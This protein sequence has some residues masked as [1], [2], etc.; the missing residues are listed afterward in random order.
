VQEGTRAAPLI[1]KALDSNPPWGGTPTAAALARADAYFTTGA[2][3]SLKGEKYV[4]L[5]T[6]GGPNCNDALRC[7]IDQCT[8]NI[9]GK[10]CGP[11][12]TNCCDPNVDE[13]GP[14]NCLD[15]DASVAAV[16]ALAKHGIKTFVVGIPGTEAYESTLDALAAKSGVENPDAPPAYFA[17]SAKSG[18][19]GLSSTLERITAGLITSCRL[20]LESVPPVLNDV[21]VVI[22]GVEIKHDDPDGWIYDRA[23]TPPA[24]VLQGKTCE[25]LETQGAQYINVSYGCPDFEPPK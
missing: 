25:K 22:D 16:A 8:V 6:D 15:E 14:T 10:A 20:Q 12:G 21:Y 5:A 24:I 19:A 9:E 23:V 2:G 7:D 3:K 1:L 13:L 11:A 4:L 17:V 18:A